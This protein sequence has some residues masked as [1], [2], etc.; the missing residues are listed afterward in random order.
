M[1]ARPSRTTKNL[2]PT[3]AFS[4]VRVPVL[5]GQ[6]DGTFPGERPEVTRDVAT[7]PDH[8]QQALVPMGFETRSGEDGAIG[9]RGS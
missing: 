2:T 4:T 1:P 7:D 8:L 6:D 5:A 9:L 3:P